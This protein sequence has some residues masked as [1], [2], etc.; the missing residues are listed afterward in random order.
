MFWSINMQLG[1]LLADDGISDALRSGGMEM[2]MGIM[3]RCLDY[4]KNYQMKRLGLTKDQRAV[5]AIYIF[6]K[7]VKS[8]AYER[9]EAAIR[10]YGAHVGASSV[11]AEIDRY[12]SWEDG[13]L[14]VMTP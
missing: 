6:S 8:P 11:F 2:Q 9:L 14:Y 7:E 12:L 1:R 10:T 4:D 5:G 13:R 3:K